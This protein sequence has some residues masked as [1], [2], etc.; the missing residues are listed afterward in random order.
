MKTPV[1]ETRNPEEGRIQKSPGRNVGYETMT[2]SFSK[3]VKFSGTK[4]YAPTAA[5]L[6]T[7]AIRCYR[8]SS[9]MTA[10]IPGGS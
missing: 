2:V 5:D 6:V 3:A 10:E 4:H 9:R 1:K 7:H 8:K